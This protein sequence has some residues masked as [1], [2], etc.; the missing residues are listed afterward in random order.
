MKRL[1]LY[2]IQSALLG[3]SIDG[4][5]MGGISSIYVPTYGSTAILLDLGPLD[6]GSARHKAATCT[7]RTAQTE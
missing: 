3:L 6:G 7:R 1:E 5:G 2:I 4:D